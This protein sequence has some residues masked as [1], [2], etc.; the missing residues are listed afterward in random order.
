MQ[1]TDAN[2]TTNL[3][4]VVPYSGVTTSL[5]ITIVCLS[6]GSYALLFGVFFAERM[7]KKNK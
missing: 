1:T 6:V 7:I 5:I 3:I 4:Q 2:M